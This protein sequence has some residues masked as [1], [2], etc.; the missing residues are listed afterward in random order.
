MLQLWS[1]ASVPSVMGG[2]PLCR[3]DRAWY[4]RRPGRGAAR[5]SKLAQT[6]CH[7][8]ALG[9]HT[10]LGLP[11]SAVIALV[12]RE[13]TQVRHAHDGVCDIGAVAVVTMYVLRRRHCHL[14]LCLCLHGARS[15]DTEQSKWYRCSALHAPRP[16]ESDPRRPG[17]D[18][19]PGS[20]RT[21]AKNRACLLASGSAPSSWT[22]FRPLGSL[23]SQHS[24]PRTTVSVLACLA[25][26]GVIH[27]SKTW[28]PLSGQR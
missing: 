4:L 9:M 12:P 1:R 22:A 27:L 20:A 14:C 18:G 8:W 17:L 5:M 6:G 26:L 24:G 21:T 15:T 19:F 3:I 16:E 13:Q 7:C 2:G 28:F 10:F 11:G 23:S 25:L